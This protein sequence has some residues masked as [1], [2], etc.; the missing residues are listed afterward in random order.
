[1]LVKE[2]NHTRLSPG[3]GGALS[4]FHLQLFERFMQAQNNI[5]KE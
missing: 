5:F 2:Q 4:S 3:G 1:M